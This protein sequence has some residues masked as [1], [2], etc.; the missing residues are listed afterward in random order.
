MQ[1]GTWYN[2]VHCIGAGQRAA[3]LK[4]GESSW[5]TRVAAAC[6]EAHVRCHDVD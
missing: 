5:L 6:A 3:N 4:S 2:H 1:H